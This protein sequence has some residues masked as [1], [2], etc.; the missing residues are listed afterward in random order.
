[1]KAFIK[2]WVIRIFRFLRLDHVRYENMMLPPTY[3]RLCGKKFKQNHFF[4]GSAKSEADRLG[5]QYGLT[6]DSSILDFGCGVGRLPIGILKQLGTVRRYCGID[7]SNDSIRWCQR[8][9][10][11]KYPNFEFIF[12]DAKNPR[13][14]PKGVDT[15][16]DLRLPFKENEFDIIYL[17]SVFSHM[18]TEDVTAYLKEFGRILAPSGKIFLTAFIA[19][20][21]PDI[22][23]NPSDYSLKIWSGPLH[24]VRYN[25]GFL[26]KMFA[27]NNFSV[28]HIDYETETD[29][30]SAFN[31]SKLKSK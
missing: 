31:I 21:V 15:I 10:G 3:L 12:I 30:Q 18:T 9:I 24:C 20:N 25:K 1:M 2:K 16:S 14:N 28:D 23:I 7:V 8:Y 26:L 4:L 11:S 17:Y 22:T 19:D 5:Q 6:S 13:Y 29:G 27:E